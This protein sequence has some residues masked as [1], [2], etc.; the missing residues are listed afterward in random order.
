MCTRI[1]IYIKPSQRILLTEAPS[2][3]RDI[4]L[5]KVG[6]EGDGEDPRQDHVIS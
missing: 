5:L 1:L 2:L 3:K 4:H 6:G